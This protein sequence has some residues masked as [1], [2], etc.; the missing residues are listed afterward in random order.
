MVQANTAVTGKSDDECKEEK[1]KGVNQNQAEDNIAFAEPMKVDPQ[2]AQ[3]ISE[4]EAP[5]Y[6]VQAILVS[7]FCFSPMG[8][9]AVLKSSECR[10][11]RMVGDRD[12]ALHTSKETKKFALIALI[13]SIAIILFGVVILVC[14]VV[15]GHGKWVIASGS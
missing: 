3:V 7:L 11:A 4:K 12:R 13:F 2:K 5:D 10:W 15:F 9:V 1:G 8:I 6:L 14:L